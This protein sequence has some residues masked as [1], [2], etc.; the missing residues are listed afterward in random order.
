MPATTTRQPAPAAV[1]AAAA[2]HVI[3]APRPVLSYHRPSPHPRPALPQR[4]AP[5]SPSASRH[6]SHARLCFH[7]RQTPLHRGCA[8]W[9]SPVEAGA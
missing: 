2:Q 4:P 9:A 5:S 8:G 7:P 3:D 1:P 6:S